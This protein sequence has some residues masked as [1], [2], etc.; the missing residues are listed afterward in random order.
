M[1]TDIVVGDEVRDYPIEPRNHQN[2]AEWDLWLEKVNLHRK[3]KQEEQKAKRKNHEQT[4]MSI[5]DTF[6]GKK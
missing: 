1:N 2:A 4:E 5:H 3:R 6:I